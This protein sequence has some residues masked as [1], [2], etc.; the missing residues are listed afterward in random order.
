MLA[1]R[2]AIERCFHS[3]VR[4]TGRQETHADFI[5]LRVAEDP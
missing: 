2:D 5:R 1:Y 4:R 3:S